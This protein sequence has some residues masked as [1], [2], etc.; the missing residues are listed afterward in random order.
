MLPEGETVV[1]LR[2]TRSIM[3]KLF[4]INT[5]PNREYYGEDWKSLLPEESPY[6]QL[7]K[8]AQKC[9]ILGDLGIE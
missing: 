5:D 6:V 2:Q 3:L 4:I 7:L 1:P 8:I 9:E